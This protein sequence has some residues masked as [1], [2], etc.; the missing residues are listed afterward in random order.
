MIKEERL[1]IRIAEDVKELLKEMAE[2]EEE[3][4]SQCVE[5]LIVQEVA[6]NKRMKERT[7]AELKEKYPNATDVEIYISAKHHIVALNAIER[8]MAFH[9]LNKLR[10]KKKRDE[11]KEKPEE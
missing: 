3:S 2:Y 9:N 1:Q 6:R 11:K 7:I 4:M 8:R 10:L 5:R